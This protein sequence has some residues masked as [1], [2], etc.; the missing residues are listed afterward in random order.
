MFDVSRQAYYEAQITHERTSVAYM[1]VLTLVRE[2]WEDMPLL[3]TR[4][5]FHLLIPELEKHG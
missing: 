4:K 1:I 2:F 5:L 3:G